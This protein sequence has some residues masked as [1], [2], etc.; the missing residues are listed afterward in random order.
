M[1]TSIDAVR[2]MV[3]LINETDRPA[4]PSWTSGGSWPNLSYTTDFDSRAKEM[5]DRYSKRVHLTG[6]ERLW[7]PAVTLTAADSKIEFASGEEGPANIVRV[8]GNGKDRGR[9]LGVVVSGGLTLLKD[10][11][12]NSTAFNNGDTVIVDYVQEVEFD[13]VDSMIQPLIVDIAKYHFVRTYRSEDKELVM[14]VAEDAKVAASTIAAEVAVPQSGYGQSG[15]IVGSLLGGMP[16]Q[17]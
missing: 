11:T 17:G 15:Y 13:G 5:L 3:G 2:E 10:L 4:T 7:T 9:P 6:P 16:Q 8:R 14:M 12:I 1:L